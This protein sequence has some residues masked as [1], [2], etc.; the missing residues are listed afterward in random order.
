V[1]SQPASI[2][3]MDV[4][5]VDT[6][7]LVIDMDA[8]EHNLRTMADF[9]KDKPANLRPH[10]KTHK[11]A[12]IAQ[13][14]IA[15][16]AVGI[17]CAKLGEAEI[18]AEA[19][20]TDVLIANQIIGPVKI[21]RLVALC[22]HTRVTVAADSPENLRDL[23][24]AA[25]AQGVTLDV[26]VEVN[27]G[28]NRCGVDPGEPAVRLA[29][30]AAD[31][32]GLRF[33]GIQAYEGHL[34]GVQELSARTERVH[35]A[36]EPIVATRRAIEASGLPVEIVTGGGTGT[37]MVTGAI[38]GFDEVQAGSYIFMDTMYTGVSGVGERFKQALSVHATVISRPV[39]ERVILDTGRKTVGID[40]GT[41][42]LKGYPEGVT[43]R[44]FSEEHTTLIAAEGPARDLRPGDRVEV[45]PG[46]VCTTVNLYDQYVC[47]RGGKVEALWP[48][49]ARGRSQ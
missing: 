15:H 16:G 32:P 11:S 12:T 5:A 29:Q 25:E 43:F 45:V 44:G 41:P 27:T 20:V 39:P 42:A 24:R 36:M 23:S 8:M 3:G 49:G 33:R 17:T 34:V 6:P 2:I 22:H 46:H 1:T 37:F 30:F 7:A 26:L 28:M 9:F 31:L 21:P 4:A 10:A 14:Q 40:H 13:K 47:V 38:E 35:A 19:G 48:I 18:M